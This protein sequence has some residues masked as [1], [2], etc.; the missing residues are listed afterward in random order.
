MN[1]YGRRAQQYYQQ[2]LPT[3]YAQIA[4]PVE[5]FTG[6]GRQMAEQINAL[7]LSLAG[8]D[9]AGETYLQKVG[10]LRM[11]R[12]Q[13]EEQVVRQTLPASDESESSS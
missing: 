13:A 7:A 3:R 8:D 1:K 9:P 2:F 6:L 12:L 5:F 4:D 11:A 10:R